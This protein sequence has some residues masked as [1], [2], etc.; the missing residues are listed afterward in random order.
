MLHEKALIWLTVK[1]T[2]ETRAEQN[3]IRSLRKKKKKITLN[4]KE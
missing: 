3:M 4:K 1:Y 2:S